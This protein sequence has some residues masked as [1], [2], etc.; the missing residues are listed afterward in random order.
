MFIFTVLGGITSVVLWGFVGYHLIE[1]FGGGIKGPLFKNPN[2]IGSLIELAY[3]ALQATFWPV[4]VIPW[5]VKML[6]RS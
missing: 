3:L 2:G 5:Q 6:F 4:I 1:K